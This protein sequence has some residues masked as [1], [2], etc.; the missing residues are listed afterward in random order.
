MS[1]PSQAAVTPLLD[2]ASRGDR[3][4]AARLL[5]L[6]YEELRE[7]AALSL[8]RERPSHTLQP[9]AIVHEA[10]LRL[11]DQTAV[12]WRG[13]T[14]FFAVAAEMMRR[15]LVDHARKRGATKRGGGRTRVALDEQVASPHANDDLDLVALDEALEE[16]H[17]LS[18]RQ[19]RVVELRYF[20][21]L[22]VEDVAAVLS[23]SDRTVKEDWRI[24]RAWLRRRLEK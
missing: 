2:S 9:T 11:V 24:A 15:V 18:E 10:F 16:L 21:G 1:G 7:R 20:G 6:V 14:H 22:N 8:R 12:D 5:P 4:A 23:V 17:R 3:R 13:R 19:A